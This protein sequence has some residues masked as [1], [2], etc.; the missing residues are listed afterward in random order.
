M[1][2]LPDSFLDYE[3]V[4]TGYWHIQK[5]QAILFPTLLR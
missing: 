4:L 3:L 5:D 1:P 2:D